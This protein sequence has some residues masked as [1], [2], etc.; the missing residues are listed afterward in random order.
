MSI[1]SNDTRAAVEVLA[2]ALQSVAETVALL[3]DEVRAEH[4]SLQDERASS[5]R[6]LLF[7]LCVALGCVLWAIVALWSGFVRVC[8]CRRAKYTPEP[9]RLDTVA[10][11]DCSDSEEL[12]SHAG[13]TLPPTFPNH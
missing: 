6:V 13:S 10:E 1:A 8:L 12:R 4:V 7:V 5:L 2:D 11:S 3:S 9:V